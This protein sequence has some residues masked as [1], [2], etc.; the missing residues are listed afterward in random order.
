MVNMLLIARSAAYGLVNIQTW[1]ADLCL[2]MLQNRVGNTDKVLR[3]SAD[4][5][6]YNNRSLILLQCVAFCAELI[7]QLDKLMTLLHGKLYKLQYLLIKWRAQMMTGT[8][9]RLNVLDKR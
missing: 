3:F 7:Q 4:V 2:L 9:N 1:S 8:N 5:I 6:E